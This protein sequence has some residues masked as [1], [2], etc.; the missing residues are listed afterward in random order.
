MTWQE[1]LAEWAVW[2]DNH[3]DDPELIAGCARVGRRLAEGLK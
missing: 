2:L 3:L 1:Q